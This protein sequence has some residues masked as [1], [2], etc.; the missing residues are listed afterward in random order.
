MRIVKKN[1]LI[2][3]LFFLIVSSSVFAT[4]P[5]FSTAG[6]FSLPNTGR[7]AYSMNVAWRFNKGN[8]N[9]A[10]A[11]VYDDSKWQIVSLPHGIEYLPV[12]ASGGINYQGIVWYRKHFTPPY[13]LKGKKLFLHFE[14]IMGKCK[15]W[16]NGALLTEHFGGYLPVVIDVTDKLNWVQDNVIAVCADNSDD[17]TYPPGKSV[18]TLDFTY[19]GGIYRDCWLIANNYTF[20]TDP[21][22]VNEVAGGGFF[23]SF[24]KISDQSAIV[25]LKMQVK[26]ELKESFTGI[27]EIDLLQA[28]GK[29]VKVTSQN[30]LAKSAESISV[31]KS[32]ELQ[33]PHLWSPESPYQYSVNVCIK[34]KKGIIVDGYRQKVG[35]RSIEFIGKEGLWLNG[36]PYNKPLIGANRHQDFAVVGNALSNSTHWRDAKKLKDIGFNIIRLSHYPQDP[37]FMDACDEL[38]MFVIIPTP[39]WQYWN[40][41]PV[42]GQRVESDIRNMIRRDRNHPSVM[43]WEPILNE[44]NYPGYSREVQGNTIKIVTEEYPYKYC[45][46]AGGPQ[47]S[48]Q[49]VYGNTSNPAKVGFY[50]EYGDGG[51]VNDWYGQNSDNRASRAWGETPMLVQSES[52]AKSANDEIY[53]PFYKNQRN[54]GGC[55]WHSFDTQRG[56][57]PVTFYGGLMDAFRQPKYA[58]YMYMAQRD[59]NG[60]SSGTGPMV[61]IAHDMSPFSPKDVTVYSNC[62]EVR[63]TVFKGGKQYTYRTDSIKIKGIPFPIIK[64]NDVYS[65]DS[66]R[67][68]ST[69]NKLDNVYMEA[70][71][72]IDGKVVAIHK[73]SPSNRAEKL[74]LRL[75]NEGVDLIANGSDFVTFVA[76]IADKNGTVKRL[77]NNFV[78]FYLEGEGRILGDESAFANPRPVV[79]GDAPVLIQ[80]TTKAGSI[81]IKVKT[82]FEGA[83]TATEGEIVI[84]S[85]ES[86]LPSIYDTKELSF[87]DKF[88]PVRN[89]T[90]SNQARTKEDD[91]KKIQDQQN[92]FLQK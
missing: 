65:Y 4:Q 23:V 28:D 88:M 10:F 56:Y 33:N 57:S 36:K 67:S 2:I 9:D 50:R 13:E 54:L 59:P 8:A 46:P 11:N 45:Y 85:V 82:C 44:T 30:I 5:E 72:I 25:N 14:A 66:W 86:K 53:E 49:V 26:N 24:D 92:L 18:G 68:L 71:G 39:G 21:N 7:K 31:L 12:E 16:V 64:F 6:F 27:V 62:D 35:I 61:Y 17:A 89:N 29:V 38:G 47:D 58:Y 87:M 73:V 32:I 37:S 60:N 15:I 83:T 20:F 55:I 80:S 3:V 19:A 42:F 69:A 63:L 77:Y 41:L 70:E 43:F 1:M 48:Y 40:D 75:D 81:K 91:L 78:E 51:R 52:Y 34:N 84:N 74:I 79:W 76:S 22:Y 90:T